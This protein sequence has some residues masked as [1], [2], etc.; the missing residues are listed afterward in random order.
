MRK[1]ESVTELSD[2]IKRHF[3]RGVA[4]N[5]FLS[6]SALNDEIAGGKLSVIESGG[7]LFII[8]SR[9]E[10]RILN[11]YI[12]D[13]EGEVSAIPQNTVS[14]IPYR[15]RDTALK[16]ASEYLQ[17]H[18]FSLMFKRRRMSRKAE[19]IECTEESVSPALPSELKHV[20]E[21]MFGNFD[22]RTACIPS[23]EAIQAAIVDRRILVYRKE[24]IPVGLLHFTRTKSGT[25]LRHLAVDNSYRGCGVGSA[26]VR[27]Y[28]A[29]TEGNSTV[30][31]R[32]DNTPAVKVY[33]KYGYTADGMMSDV[34]IT[35]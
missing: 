11:F 30:W 24:G 32:V 6:S 28:L 2:I 23:G 3:V 22:I 19:H 16:N 33:E 35:K 26:L 29:S 1:I 8:R 9:T 34:L 25:E 17:A 7:N 14:E 27:Y 10:H 18:G 13:T 4:T 15:E 20:Y 31:V 21:I 5:N 12:T